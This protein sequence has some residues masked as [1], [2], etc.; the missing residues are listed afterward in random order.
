MH[1]GKMYTSADKIDREL[2]VVLFDDALRSEIKTTKNITVYKSLRKKGLVDHKYL[3]VIS[4]AT[5]LEKISAFV[6][7]ANKKNH[8]RALLIRSDIDTEILP[9]LMDNAKLRSLRNTLYHEDPHTPKRILNAWASGAQNSLI[10]NAS[11]KENIL[12]VVSCALQFYT[13]EFKQIPALQ[14]LPNKERTHFQI[15]ED[16]RYVY[17]ENQ[18]I[19]IDLETIKYYT[20][21]EYREEVDLQKMQYFQNIG[22]AIKHI[23]K[24]SGLRQVDIEGFSARQIRRIENGR[25]QLNTATLQKL[26][27]SH[28]MNL[29]DYLDAIA[30]QQAQLSEKK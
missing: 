7:E 23:R 15:A 5:N 30:S 19:H 26:A 11:V 18:D 22:E 12:F 20:N 16:G 10:A 14:S 28:K 17:W 25:V 4:Q 6:S 3:F 13:C 8:L 1:K 2:S 21:K 29:D 24:E 27:N 9:K